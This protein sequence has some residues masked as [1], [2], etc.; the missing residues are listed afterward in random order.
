MLFEANNG[1]G[2][3]E[4]N[5]MEGTANSSNILEISMFTSVVLDIHDKIRVVF[6]ADPGISTA[7]LRA[8]S[9][10]SGYLPRT[11]IYSLSPTPIPTN[12]PTQSPIETGLLVDYA[13]LVGAEL[14]I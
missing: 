1:S 8:G 12:L 10:F 13:F 4:L 3:E 7:T 14:S 11:D 9:T 5:R 6:C 2:F